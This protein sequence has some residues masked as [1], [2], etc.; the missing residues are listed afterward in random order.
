MEELGEA[1][2]FD[3][4]SYIAHLKMGELWMRLRVCT[5]AVDHTR[6]AAL[7]GQESSTGR[8]SA[9]PGRYHQRIDAERNRT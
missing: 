9:A 4:N 2:S 5:K 6:Q 8:A 1:V 3:P 7:L